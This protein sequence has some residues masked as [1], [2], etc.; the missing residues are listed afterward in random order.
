IEIVDAATGSKQSW[1]TPALKSNFPMAIDPQTQRVLVV[2]RSPPTLLALSIKEQRVA[3]KVETCGD[4][5][6][7]FVDAKRP[8]L[9]VSCGD[10]M[11]DVFAEDGTGY[12][13]LARVPTAPGART[14]LFVPDWTGSLSRCGPI[15]ASQRRSGCSVQPHEAGTQPVKRQGFSERQ[16]V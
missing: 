15:R 3:A 6:D 2:F 16:R 12:Q 7:V 13:P 8:R 10:G 4:A 1:P 11:V 9:Y 5:D 14:S